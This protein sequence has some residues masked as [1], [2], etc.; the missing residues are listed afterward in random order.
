VDAGDLRIATEFAST[1]PLTRRT[2][3]GAGL[4]ALILKPAMV[5]TVSEMNDG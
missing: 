2:A 1:L 3:A 4:F 5:V